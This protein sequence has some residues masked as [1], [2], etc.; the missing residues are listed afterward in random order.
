MQKIEKK[1]IDSLFYEIFLTGKYIKK[2]GE[3]HFKKLK[4]GLTIEE[5]STLDFLYENSNICQRDLAL[6]MLINRANMGKILNGLENKG[7]IKR[8]LD[9]RA[10]HPVK[11][12]S[13]T[14]QGKEIYTKTLLT[15]KEQ[16]LPVIDV[17]AK[18]DSDKIISG[19]TKIREAIKEL[20]EINI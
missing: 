3:Q 9:I 19:L 12:V 6:R 14:K 5:F 2:L 20:I 8:E 15:L 1:Y 17:I 11:I 13:L 7:Y 10:N 18:D 4:P 16:S